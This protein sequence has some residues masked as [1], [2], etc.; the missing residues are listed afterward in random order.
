MDHHFQGRP[1]LPA[2]V[3]MEA[4]ARCVKEQHPHLRIDSFTDAAFN[5]FL[6]MDPAADGIEAMAELQELQDGRMQATL[7]TRFKPPKAPF[8]R[9]KVHVRMTFGSGMPEYLLPPMDLLAALEGICTTVPPDA[10]YKDLVPFGPS[11]RNIKTPLFISPDGA[12]AHI[13]TP[14]PH[15][16]DE[17]HEHLLGSPFALDAAFHAACVWA[18]HYQGMVA[19]PVAIDRLT[20]VQPTRPAAT[21]YGRILPPTISADRLQFDIIVMDESGQVRVIAQGVH[22]RDVSGGRL[23]PPAWIR[24]AD[25]PDPLALLNK[26]CSAM[27]VVELDAVAGFAPMTLTPLEMQRHEQMGDRRRRSF[28]AARLALKRLYRRCRQNDTTT[29]AHQIETVSED[30]SRPCMGPMDATAAYACSAS[31]DRRFALASADPHPL[32]VDVETISAKAFKCRR[33]FMHPAEEE[34]VQHSPL[35]DKTAAMRIWSVKEAAA[36][37]TGMN[38]AQAWHRVRV[39]DLDAEQSRLLVDQK[40]MTALHGTMDDHLFTLICTGDD[41]A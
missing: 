39:T 31:H 36:K 15:P 27:A 14:R 20:I 18:Q 26:A 41:T 7:L 32:G 5:K 6:F 29:P 11:F 13:E 19:F 40:Q 21:Y 3:A 37:C 17:A 38:L 24:Q 1:V 9:T 8:T 33:I 30:S 22:M 2:V 4:L 34:L 25:G 35:D 12:L 16:T 23:Q 28:L 10:I